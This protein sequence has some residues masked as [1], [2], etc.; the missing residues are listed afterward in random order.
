MIIAEMTYDDFEP[1]SDFEKNGSVNVYYNLT[2][3]LSSLSHKDLT[4]AFAFSWDFYMVL[5]ILIGTISVAVSA[6]FM[7]YHR[8]VARPSKKSLHIA[9]FKFLSYIKLTIPPAGYGLMLA[10]IP[11]IMVD[12]FIAIII[13]GHFLTYKVY[14]FSCDNPGGES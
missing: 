10:L 3:S 8:L 6:V 4:I 2:F 13:S 7:G 1:I 11:V 9:K 12:L 5:Y 14:L